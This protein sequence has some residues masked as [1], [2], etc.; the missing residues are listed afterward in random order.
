MSFPDPLLLRNKPNRLTILSAFASDQ[1]KRDSQEDAF[2]QEKDECFAMADGIGGMPHGHEA[3]SLAAE[4]VV[5]TYKLTKYKPFYWNDKKL[6]VGRIFRSANWRVYNKRRE[7][8]FEGGLASTLLVVMFSERKFYICHV[9]DTQAIFYRDGKLRHITKSD[10]DEDGAITKAIG[11]NHKGPIPS[12][13]ADDVLPGDMIVM[14]TDGVSDWVTDTE[15]KNALSEKLD[16]P[17]L[18]MGQATSL[19]AIARDHGSTDN[20]SV[21]IISCFAGKLPQ[22]IV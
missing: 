6:L 10:R 7:V 9:G 14:A 1:G 13:F 16:T 4:A 19:I 5:W 21:C 17:Q 8:G 11:I 2:F 20:A 18:L 3:A 22:Y 15:W 12:Y